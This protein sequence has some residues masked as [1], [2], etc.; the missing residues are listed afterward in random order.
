M[1]ISFFVDMHACHS[2]WKIS[3]FWLVRFS[4]NLHASGI[5]AKNSSH[6][7]RWLSIR[8]KES[9]FRPMFNCT[10]LSVSDVH[11]IVS[12]GHKCTMHI[13]TGTHALSSAGTYALD[14]KCSCGYDLKTAA[15]IWR[16]IH[17]LC[18]CI[19]HIYIRCYDLCGWPG[20]ATEKNIKRQLN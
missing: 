13:R 20:G 9:P 12:S 15:T 14:C 10:T 17:P 6:R 11:A 5:F 7:R 4:L 18:E 1:H 2:I 16:A 3:Y 19:L 8:S